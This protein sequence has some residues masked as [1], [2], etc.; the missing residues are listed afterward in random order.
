MWFCV[1][2]WVATVFAF[3]G[4]PVSTLVCLA[5]YV[6]PALYRAMQWQAPAPERLALAKPFET[7]HALSFFLPVKLA[8]DEWGRRWAHPSP[9]NGSGDFTALVVLVDIAETRIAPNPNKE[10]HVQKALQLVE[11]ALTDVTVTFGHRRKSTND[12][13]EAAEYCANLLEG[14][15]MVRL[16]DPPTV[17]ILAGRKQPEAERDVRASRAFTYDLAQTLKKWCEVM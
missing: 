1:A 13:L 14:A 4:M 2:P 17:K 9:T 12:L 6:V 3:P 11:E 8:V 16:I 7:R 5:R 15:E 10:G